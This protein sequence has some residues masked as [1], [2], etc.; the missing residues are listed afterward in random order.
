LIFCPFT[1]ISM[2]WDYCS[3][4]QRR[5]SRGVEHVSF[6]PHFEK[7]G[8]KAMF[9]CCCQF[10]KRHPPVWFRPKPIS[11]PHLKLPPQLTELFGPFLEP[12]PLLHT[13]THTLSDPLLL[14]WLWY[15]NES[16]FYKFPIYFYSAGYDIS[17]S[18]IST[19]HQFLT[20][21]LIHNIA[22]ISEHFVIWIVYI[23][24]CILSILV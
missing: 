6:P 13:Q 4:Q 12:A 24:V 14:R 20:T 2:G 7:E 19:C 1:K 18:L 5:W 23:C 11:G 8:G 22:A 10:W 3:Y 17:M 16:Y 9:I 21:T 15:I